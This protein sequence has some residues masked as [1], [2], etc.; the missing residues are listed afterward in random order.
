MRFA[1]QTGGAC[2]SLPPELAVVQSLQ[3]DGH[4]GLAQLRRQLQ[5]SLL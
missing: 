2:G 1:G 4:C 3:V 5:L